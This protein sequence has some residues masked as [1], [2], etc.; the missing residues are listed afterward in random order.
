[1][2]AQAWR[3]FL[4]AHVIESPTLYFADEPTPSLIGGGVLR[5]FAVTIDQRSR[6]VRFEDTA[7]DP[8]RQGS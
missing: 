1:M 2:G 5:D 3:G 7:P 6:L 8:P 4:G